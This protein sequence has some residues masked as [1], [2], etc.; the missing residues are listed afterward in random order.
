MALT[1]RS[2]PASDGLS[3][4]TS[5]PRS[6]FSPITRG[7]T[8]RYRRARFLRL[9]IDC[10]T[11][12]E[13]MQPSNTP[14]CRPAIAR[15][16]DSQTAYSSAVRLDSVAARHWADHFSPSCTAN[17][18]LVL[19]CSMASSMGGLLRSPEEDVAR[20]YPLEG[21][22]VQ[23]QP[24]RTVRV[25]ALGHALQ[26]PGGQPRLAGPAEADRLEAPG[27][28]DRGEALG[29]PD[30]SPRLE[31]G[32]QHLERGERLRRA[33]RHMLGERRGRPLDVQRSVGEVH[34]E[35]H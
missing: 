9:K 6:A 30:L 19:P 11:T 20:R 34:A 32:R 12:L 8:C 10:G 16:C 3:I 23:P 28:R 25:E 26:R 17:R 29:R 5:I 35:S 24:E 22:V 21:A 15:S 31:P 14:S 27:A 7:S 33:A 13:M 2:A 1:R 18:V 4:R